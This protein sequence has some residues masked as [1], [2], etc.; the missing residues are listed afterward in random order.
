MRYSV[1][2]FNISQ[3]ILIVFAGGHSVSAHK[4]SLVKFQLDLLLS[5][6]FHQTVLLQIAYLATN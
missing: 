6:M 4:T 3:N 2:I 5:R 1:N